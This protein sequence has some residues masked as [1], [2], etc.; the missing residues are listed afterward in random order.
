MEERPRQLTSR[1]S[2]K[3]G[4]AGSAGTS[5]AFIYVLVVHRD[6]TYP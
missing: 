5:E 3:V 1:P 2:V 6:E 4:R